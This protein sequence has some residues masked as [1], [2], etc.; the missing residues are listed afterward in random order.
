[1]SITA[2]IERE[3]RVDLRAGVVAATIANVNRKRGQRPYTPRDFFNSLR[4]E[5][6]EQ[7]SEQQQKALQV[8]AVASGAR[9]KRVSREELRRIAEEGRSV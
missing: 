1:M 4:P 8:I 7:T 2:Y 5:R 9:V 6:H 3:K